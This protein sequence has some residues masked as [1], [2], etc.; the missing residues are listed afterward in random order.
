MRL[1]SKEYMLKT[2]PIC[3]NPGF[4]PHIPHFVPILNAGIKVIHSHLVLFSSA[5]LHRAR[6]TLLDACS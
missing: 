6:E 2:A 5:K 3:R 1:N 4:G